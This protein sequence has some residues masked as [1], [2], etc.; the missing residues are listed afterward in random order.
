MGWY[1]KVEIYCGRSCS[2]LPL[3]TPWTSWILK[4]G[5]GMSCHIFDSLSGGQNG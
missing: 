1:H 5:Q 3:G 2:Y 4:E